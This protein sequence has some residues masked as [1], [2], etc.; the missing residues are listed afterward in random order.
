MLAAA[1]WKSDRTPTIWVVAEAGRG[2]DWMGGGEANAML[3]D[4]SGTTVATA[5]AAIE[6]NTRTVR[7]ALNPATELPPG[8]YDIRIRVK[9]A[10]SANATTDA[11]RVS[12]SAAPRATGAV[13][14]RRGPTTG[15]R[16]VA[17]ADLRFRRS[18]QLKVEVPTLSSD[19]VSARLLDR[20]GKVLPVIPV[21]ASTR[22]DPDGSRWQTAQ[23][24]LVPLGTGDYVIEV[25]S[26][27]GGSGAS[28]GPE[29]TRTLIAFRVV[30]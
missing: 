16:D 1:G 28:G 6:P 21:T 15:N 27:A 14:L 20:T 24:S 12:L 4:R 17:T 7:L 19:P 26:G 2:E 13:F 25:T 9:G 22:V 18:D 3:L 11:T 29:T 8:D 5:R 23:L 10:A 30:P